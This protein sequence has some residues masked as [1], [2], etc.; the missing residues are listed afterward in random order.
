LNSRTLLAGIR[1]VQLRKLSTV[2]IDLLSERQSVLFFNWFARRKLLF[3]C[4]YLHAVFPESITHMRACRQPGAS[5]VSDNLPLL[6]PIASFHCPFTH[7]QVLCSIYIVVLDLYVISIAAS[8]G[9]CNHDTVAGRYDR[10]SSWCRK[11]GPQMR[12]P[13]F[14]DRVQSPGTEA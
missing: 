10:S 3:Q 2:S 13:N 1:R 7:M 6:Y 8:V 9:R 12:F 5:H 14:R 11:I 4:V